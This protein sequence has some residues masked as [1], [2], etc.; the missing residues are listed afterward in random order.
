MTRHARCAGPCGTSR[1]LCVDARSGIG[2]GLCHRLLAA[3]SLATDQP[4]TESLPQ[5]SAFAP[6]QSTSTSSL[7]TPPRAEITLT[8]ILACRSLTKAQVAKEQL[9]ERHLKLLEKRRRAGL[10]TPET[11]TKGLRLD[12]ELLDVDAPNGEN[13]ILDFCQRLRTR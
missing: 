7:P 11:W 1:Y 13:G 9:L 5:Y 10:T 12:I 4:I 2:L 3:L 8:L 6:D